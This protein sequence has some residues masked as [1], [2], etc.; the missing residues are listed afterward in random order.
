[1]N[2]PQHILEFADVA[3]EGT[4]FSANEFLEFGSR[5]TID[6][7]LSRLAAQGEILR[8][9]RGW[10]T[11][12]VRGRFGERP[13]EPQAVVRAWAERH[14]VQVAPAGAASANQLGLTTQV[15]AKSIW[16]TTGQ[17]TT[18]TIGNQ[19]VP[20]KTSPAWQVQPGTA[21]AL[22][23]AVVWFGKEAPE[24]TWSHVLRQLEEKERAVLTRA[25]GV[26]PTW[27]AER[28]TIALS[29]GR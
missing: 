26:M 4:T 21:G 8:V 7:A 29:R 2:A 13:P 17:N 23:R 16:L 28:F 22:L 10:Y 15:P 14:F 12:P 19:R 18:L 20:L 9:G 25:L 27:M 6:A 1:M 5:S 11:A 3:P 24:S